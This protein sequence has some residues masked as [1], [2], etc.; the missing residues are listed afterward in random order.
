MF[1]FGKKV[2]E[3]LFE[4]Y[5]EGLSKD[6]PEFGEIPRKYHAVIQQTLSDDLLIQRGRAQDLPKLSAIQKLSEIA[7]QKAQNKVSA[8]RYAKREA[9]MNQK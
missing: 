1:R 6:T 5:Y 8:D 3:E 9:E 2:E 7:Y 4:I